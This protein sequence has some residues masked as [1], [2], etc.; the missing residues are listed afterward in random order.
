MDFY[1][2]EHYPDSTAAEAIRRV[3]ARNREKAE[4]A[5]DEG[6]LRLI[7]A[8][9]RQAVEDYAR[10]LRRLSGRPDSP[11]LKETEAFFRSEHFHRLSRLNGNR[12]L[13]MIRK[14]M[15]KE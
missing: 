9:I 2:A 10:E 8:I 1:N 4:A 13:R 6:C 5:A 11:Q 12:I 14:E 3:T 15:E 7:E